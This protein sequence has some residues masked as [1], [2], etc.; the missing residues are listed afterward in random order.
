MK[1]ARISMPLAPTQFKDKKTRAEKVMAKSKITAARGEKAV[2]EGR[3]EK[4]TRLLKK[5]ARQETRSIRVEERI[6]DRKLKKR[7]FNNT[8]RDGIA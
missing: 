5:A 7:G 8:S 1:D 4:A 3:D 6:E 2:D